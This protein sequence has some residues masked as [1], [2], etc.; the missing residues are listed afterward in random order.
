MNATGQGRGHQTKAGRRGLRIHRRTI[1]RRNHGGDRPKRGVSHGRGLERRG[2]HHE[3]A[4][5]SLGS[6]PGR[7]EAADAN[8][9]KR[10]GQSPYALDMAP[11]KHYPCT[12]ATW[13][14]F[15]SA[16]AG[17]MA[18]DV[19]RRLLRATTDPAEHPEYHTPGRAHKLEEI[20][21]I[22]SSRDDHAIEGEVIAS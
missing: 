4:V 2:R 6:R 14:I 21:D 8:V 11:V 9:P 17:A 22:V 19:W 1:S 10:T 20:D 3:A 5:I 18:V 15:T 7:R 12:D 13:P 16:E